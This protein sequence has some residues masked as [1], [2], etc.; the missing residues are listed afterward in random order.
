MSLGSSEHGG[1]LAGLAYR[2]GY[3]AV[4]FER[5]ARMFWEAAEEGEPFPT[6]LERSLQ[7]V[8]DSSWELAPLLP[9]RTGRRLVEGLRKAA[10]RALDALEKAWLDTGHVAALDLLDR[11]EPEEEVDPFTSSP[12]EAEAWMNF[13]RAMEEF[14]RSL[15]R[16]LPDSASLGVHVAAARDVLPSGRMMRGTRHLVADPPFSIIPDLLSDVA[17]DC[18]PFRGMEID[19]SEER[20]QKADTGPGTTCWEWRSAEV[21]RL[22][23]AILGLGSDVASGEPEELWI[24]A[25]EAS[26][27]AGSYD[28]PLGLPAISKLASSPNPPFKSRHR[29]S[30]RSNRPHLR[31]REV[32]L[33][34]FYKYIRGQLKSRESQPGDRSAQAKLEGQTGE[35]RTGEPTIYE[36]DR[37]EPSAVERTRIDR[38]LAEDRELRKKGRMKDLQDNGQ[39]DKGDI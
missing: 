31:R 17:A 14:S 25:S 10:P 39:L 11:A 4:E 13:R 28:V 2:L 5:R 24:T 33:I 9:E 7:D 26:I 12:F 16:P 19:L 6:E 35:T 34:S 36:M 23:R 8:R 22:H 15:P 32:S 38:R 27:L 37:G 20:Y 30:P 1:R 18:P 3:A 29:N 21:A